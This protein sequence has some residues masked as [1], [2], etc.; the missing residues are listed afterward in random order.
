VN[1]GG[2]RGDLPSCWSPAASAVV[3][4]ILLLLLLFPRLASCLQVPRNRSSSGFTGAG[5]SS[6]ASSRPYLVQPPIRAAAAAS[7]SGGRDRGAGVMPETPVTAAP[8]SS[9]GRRLVP[10]SRTRAPST[11]AAVGPLPAPPPQHRALAGS[12]GSL[13]MRSVRAGARVWHGA[14]GQ[15]SAMRAYVRR[16]VRRAL[17]H[18][19]R[20]HGTAHTAVTPATALPPPVPAVPHQA[21][22][23]QPPQPASAGCGCV[24]M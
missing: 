8:A 14:M 7:G 17:R 12:R 9:A 3:S 24:V 11:S 18:A 13:L 21:P 2:E 20:N 6:P 10:P 4:S 5:G 1:D 16:E 15:V 22:P 19:L 23:P